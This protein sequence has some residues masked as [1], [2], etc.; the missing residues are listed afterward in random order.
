[1][2][3]LLIVLSIIGNVV[4]LPIIAYLIHKKIKSYSK[5]NPNEIRYKNQRNIHS[6]YSICSEDVVFIGD[7]HIARYDWKIPGKEVWNLGIGGDT[8][9]GVL[10]RVATVQD[11]NTIYVWVG[12]NDLIA[13]KSVESIISNLTNI[14]YALQKEGRKV[15]FINIPPV[16]PAWKYS[17]IDNLEIEVLNLFIVKN[18]RYIHMS[19]VEAM[20]LD[21]LHLN[22]FGYTHLNKHIK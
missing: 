8:S 9:E 17:K 11:A 2:I 21:G 20:S 5:P 1:M 14:N 13:G 18:F 3:K 16:W 7:S 22:G 4:T 6:T 12:I 15:I 19:Y 10:R